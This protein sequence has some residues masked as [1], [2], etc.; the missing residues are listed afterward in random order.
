M[1]LGDC[2][3]EPNQYFN[4]NSNGS[5]TDAQTDPQHCVTATH[6]PPSSPDIKQGLQMWAKPQPEGALAVFGEHSHDSSSNR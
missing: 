2:Q 5:L 6:Y 3:H 1:D 4:F